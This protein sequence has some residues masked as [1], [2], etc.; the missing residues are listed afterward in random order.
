MDGDYDA[1]RAAL[2]VNIPHI[3]RDDFKP[4]VGQRRFARLAC[5][6]LKA[7]G[8]TQELNRRIADLETLVANVPGKVRVREY[9]W[10]VI[11][12]YVLR[13]QIDEALDAYE[14]A[15]ANGRTHRW[16]DHENFAGEALRN[17]PRFGQIIEG[18]RAE[19]AE[20]RAALASEGLANP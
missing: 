6:V 13:G 20:Q 9:S 14:V 3:F 5:F 7:Q 18:I 4:A 2:E 16:W 19:V 1:A 12:I 10:D 8:Q 11:N 17:E 15:V